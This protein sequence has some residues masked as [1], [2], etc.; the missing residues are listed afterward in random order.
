MRVSYT[1]IDLSYCFLTRLDF[2]CNKDKSEKAMKKLIKLFLHGTGHLV[3]RVG[4]W[5]TSC[6]FH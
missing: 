2:T 1:S 5:M 6:I 4:G 3:E